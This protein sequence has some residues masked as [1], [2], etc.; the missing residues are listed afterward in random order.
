MSVTDGDG[1]KYYEVDNLAQEV[2]FEETT[3]ET[4]LADGVRNILK[5]YVASRRFVIEQDSSGTYLQF[6]FGSETDEQ[7]GLANPSQIAIKMHGRRSLSKLSFDPSRLLRTD[8]LG[9]SP[10]G[11][12]LTIVTKV[13]DSE[14]INVP[15]NGLQAVNNIV[16]D[17]DNIQLLSSVKTS[18]VISS[19]EATNEEPI[20]GDTSNLTNEELRVRAS[21]YYSTQNRAVTKQDYESMIYNMPNKFGSIKRVSVVNDPSASNRR[22][23]IYLISENSSQQ[24]VQANSKIKSNIKIGLCNTKH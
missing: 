8:K 12:S 6:G 16:M 22:M 10:S 5:P 7:E 2:V 14:V 9:L 3:N 19:L 11:T 1:N 18:A 20:Q 23:A 24:L 15:T 17:F 21:T 13:N 4:A